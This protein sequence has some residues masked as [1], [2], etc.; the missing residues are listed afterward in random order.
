MSTQKK[1]ARRTWEALSPE[2]KQERLQALRHKQILQIRTDLSRLD[3]L[4]AW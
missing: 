4:R 3:C 2:Q 1:Q